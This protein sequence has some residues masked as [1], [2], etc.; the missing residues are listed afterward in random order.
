M[1]LHQGEISMLY[2]CK[3]LNKYSVR[4]FTL[5]ELLVVVLIIGILAAIAVPQYQISVQKSK[6]QQAVYLARAAADAYQIYFLQTGNNSN[7]TWHDL[8]FEFPGSAIDPQNP[9]KI[10]SNKITGY[11]D[12][13]SGKE[14]EQIININFA[15][16]GNVVIYYL[17]SKTMNGRAS[18]QGLACQGKNETGYRICKALGGKLYPEYENSAVKYYSL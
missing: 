13:F 5:I 7:I 9:R 8:D 1:F 2:N 3:G 16:G 6:A 17:L 10:F 12:L 15:S 11:I 4:G 18:R 14:S